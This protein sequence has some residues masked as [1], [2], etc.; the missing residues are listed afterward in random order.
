[1]LLVFFIVFTVGCSKVTVNND[2]KNKVN[3]SIITPSENEDKDFYI[4]AKNIVDKINARGRTDKKYVARAK[5]I[6]LPD[7]FES[8]KG[9]TEKKIMSIAQNKDNNVV[10]V[11]T[12]KRGILPY[13]Q[14]LKDMMPKA[15]FIASPMG[16]TREE[17]SRVMDLGFEE[18]TDADEDKLVDL[19]EELGV[20]R[21]IQFVTARDLT[22][23]RMSD[24]VNNLKNKLAQKN[25][26]YEEIKLADIVNEDSRLSTTIEVNDTIDKKVKQYGEDIAVMGTDADMDRVIARNALKNKFIIP[27]FSNLNTV[28][29]FRELFE[30]DDLNR[31]VLSYDV[32]A[33]EVSNA[34]A[35]YKMNYRVGG[36]YC[37]YNIFLPEAASELAIDLVSKDEKISKAYK[38]K[39]I[40]DTI[41]ER[42]KIRAGYTYLNKKKNYIKAKIDLTI[43]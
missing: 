34:L 20:K 41:T 19:E 37:P 13:M 31:R 15:L 9:E 14:T 33:T 27:R 30:I 11:S 35:Q 21:H 16:E 10:I 3:I 32:Q 24:M 18:D 8:N 39:Y 29:L 43:Y 7:D 12:T 4:G 17:I 23:K 22:N 36:Y 1:M 2:G 26:P 25:I 40:D 38:E 28:D 42:T 5:H 6:V